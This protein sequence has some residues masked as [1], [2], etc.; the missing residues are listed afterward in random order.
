LFE[1][2]ACA[3]AKNSTT[4]AR[5]MNHTA[6]I[7]AVNTSEQRAFNPETDDAAGKQPCTSTT[8]SKHLIYKAFRSACRWKWGAL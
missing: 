8:Q 7:A 5:E 3:S 2:T 6:T 1:S 4:E